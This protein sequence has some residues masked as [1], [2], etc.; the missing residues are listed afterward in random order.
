M[1]TI[2][3]KNHNFSESTCEN[4]FFAIFLSKRATKN[5]EFYKLLLY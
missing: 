2:M 1:Y 4:V 5:Q 3:A